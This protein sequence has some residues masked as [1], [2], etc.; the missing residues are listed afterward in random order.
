VLPAGLQE[1]KAYEPNAAQLM[2]KEELE[3][4]NVLV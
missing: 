3:S 4:P 2:Q 1:R